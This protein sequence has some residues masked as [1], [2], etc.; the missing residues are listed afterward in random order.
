MH[1][2]P[3]P[4]GFPS[5][6]PDGLP[7]LPSLPPVQV[8]QGALQSCIEDREF[9]VLLSK[10][11]RQE[12]GELAAGKQREG[13]ALTST[14]TAAAAKTAEEGD[15]LSDVDMEELEQLAT[16]RADEIC[17]ALMA[18]PAPHGGTRGRAS[19]LEIGPE[20]DTRLLEQVRGVVIWERLNT[21]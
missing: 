1:G 15:G 17:E 20:S 7:G 18:L 4:D 9:E 12:E 21:F 8:R 14:T 10:T 11:D 6:P 19:L 13:P 3:L 2:H 16:A 5:L